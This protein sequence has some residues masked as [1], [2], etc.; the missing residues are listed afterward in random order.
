M[1]LFDDLLRRSEF[2]ANNPSRDSESSRHDQLVYPFITKGLGWKPN[3]CIPQAQ[4]KVPQTIVESHVFRNATPKSRKP[5][6]LISPVSDQGDV[7]KSVAA[8][9][10]KKRQLSLSDLKNHSLQLTEYQALSEC[11]WGILT[12]GDMWLI[13]RSFENWAEFSS[14]D[15]LC[16]SFDEVYNAIGRE[17]SLQR[18]NLTGSADLLLL[19]YT[20]PREGLI[21]NDDFSAA[22]IASL[23]R[24]PGVNWDSELIELTKKYTPEQLNEVQKEF[25]SRGELITEVE[26]FKSWLSVDPEG[27]A[28]QAGILDPQYL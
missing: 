6:I 20:T 8:I 18:L 9:E 11:V 15:E 24:K 10:E 1:T 13:K 12:D 5:D 21:S 2:L 28:I 14:L 7:M 27:C 4:L 25:V 26:Y 3:D 23:L 19:N 22:K 17:P 16:K